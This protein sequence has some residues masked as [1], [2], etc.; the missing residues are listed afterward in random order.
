[1]YYVI[2]KRFT[3]VRATGDSAFEITISWLPALNVHTMDP[4]IEGPCGVFDG[5]ETTAHGQHE[6]ITEALAKIE[7]LNKRVFTNE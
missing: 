6:T 7:L 3:D 2:E 1:M 5:V 4:V